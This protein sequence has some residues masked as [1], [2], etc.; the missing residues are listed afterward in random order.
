MSSPSSSG[1]GVENNLKSL[2][3]IKQV[4]KSLIE[5]L[6]LRAGEFK[7][8]HKT[9]QYHQYNTVLSDKIVNLLFFEPSTRTLCSFQSA[10]LKLGG[11]P[12]TL[13]IQSSSSV[14]G[15]SLQDTLRTMEQYGDLT[16]MRHP[17]RGVHQEV[18]PKL[19]KP[20]I[21]A[22]DGDGEHPTQALLDLFTITE[23]EK[24]VSQQIDFNLKTICM[25]GDLKFGRTVHSLLRLLYKYYNTQPLKLY[26]ISPSGLKMPDYVIEECVKNYGNVHE[27]VECEKLT[28]EIMKELD[29]IYATRLQKERFENEDQYLS[30][31]SSFCLK[32]DDLQHSRNQHLPIIMHPLPRVD[33]L[34]ESIDTDERAAYFR[35]MNNGVYMRMAILELLLKD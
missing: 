31:K 33:E 27:I 16:V 12:I 32:K 26:L 11:K 23:E 14:K 7:N 6:S 18:L 24:R 35:Q 13:D 21:N 25:F 9:K 4:D 1:T 29:V 28:P 34:D 5:Q 30:Y 17:K 10:V 19:E 8:Y 20:L 15:E 22:G 2:L 3:S